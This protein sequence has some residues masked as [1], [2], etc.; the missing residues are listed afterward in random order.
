MA[1]N[2]LCPRILPRACCHSSFVFKEVKLNDIIPPVL[3]VTKGLSRSSRFHVGLITMN[4]II[5]VDMMFVVIFD[6]DCLL[7]R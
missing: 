1:M 3:L 5:T 2:P 6:V 4:Y 7:T